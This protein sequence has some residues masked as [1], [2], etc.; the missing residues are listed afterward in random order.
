MFLSDFD[1]FVQET[2]LQP[3]LSPNKQQRTWA[4]GSDFDTLG[5]SPDGDVRGTYNVVTTGSGTDFLA[6]GDCDVDGD[7]NAADFEATKTTNVTMTTGA[8]VY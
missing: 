1:A 4:P 3:N 2:S 6:D 5:W 8:N 7:G